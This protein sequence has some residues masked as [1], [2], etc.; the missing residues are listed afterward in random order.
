MKTFTAHFRVME[1]YEHLG[2]RGI[3]AG[4]FAEAYSMAQAIAV[5]QARQLTGTPRQGVVTFSLEEGTAPAG[6]SVWQS[7]PA[8]ASAE[9][10]IER[11][12]AD[13]EARLPAGATLGAKI[14]ALLADVRQAPTAEVEKMIYS[15]TADQYLVGI[16]TGALKTT[17]SG[18]VALETLTLHYLWSRSGAAEAGEFVERLRYLQITPKI[19]RT[20]QLVGFIHTVAGLPIEQA[21]F[22]WWEELYEQLDDDDDIAAYKIIH[23]LIKEG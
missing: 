15:R 1:T 16:Y 23:K 3:T 22:S 5:R 6:G 14:G 18:T 19:I 9:Q 8:D 11:A 17:G 2:A 12:W 21:D 7:I 10:V 4:D 20:D 13:V